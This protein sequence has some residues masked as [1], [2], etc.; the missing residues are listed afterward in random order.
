MVVRA[1]GVALGG[2]MESVTGHR[3]LINVRVEGEVGEVGFGRDDEAGVEPGQVG[4]GLEEVEDLLGGV[5]HQS[6]VDEHDGC[7][8]EVGGGGWVPH[9]VDGSGAVVVEVGEV[10]VLSLK[11]RKLAGLHEEDG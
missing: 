1:G 7:S 6:V 8:G 4:A 11:L 2:V 9:G 10:G 5:V 3:E